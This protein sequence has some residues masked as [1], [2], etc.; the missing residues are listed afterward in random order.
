MT[1]KVILEPGQDGFITVHCPSLKSC[2]SQGRTREEA[3][4]TSAKRSSFTSSPIPK[5][6]LRMRIARWWSWLFE[7][8]SGIRPTGPSLV[9]C[10]QSAQTHHEQK[11]VRLRGLDAPYFYLDFLKHV[12]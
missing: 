11:M 3:S 10:V 2:W 5:T 12:R 4:S 9:G 8:S 1:V 6:W 7:N